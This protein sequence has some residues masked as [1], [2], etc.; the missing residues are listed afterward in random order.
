[1]FGRLQIL[2][3]SML[4][5]VLG[6]ALL[7]DPQPAASTQHLPT[8]V[9]GVL[10]ATPSVGPTE[11]VSEG[12]VD[13][14]NTND[15]V[16]LPAKVVI[17]WGGQVTAVWYRPDADVGFRGGRLFAS[18]RDTAGVWSNPVAVSQAFAYPFGVRFDVAAGRGPAASIVWTARFDG[19]NYVFEAH[20]DEIGWSSPSMLG[21]GN[22]NEPRVVMDGHGNTT[23]LWYR[24]GPRVATRPADGAW[25]APRV[26]RRG[27]GSPPWALTANRAGDEALVWRVDNGLRAT[28]RARTSNHWTRAVAVPGRVGDFVALAIDR[29]GRALAAWS[30]AGSIQWAR[31]SLHGRWSSARK[32]PGDVGRIGEYGWLDLSVNRRGR[33]LVRWTADTGTYVAR[34]QPGAGFR[35]AVHLGRLFRAEDSPLLTAG[36]T[37]IVAGKEPVKFFV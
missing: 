31:R 28:F 29:R 9:S 30:T 33:G 23:A 13:V 22:R 10:A 32:I 5:M 12:A 26:F 17:G 7:V 16:G 27:G 37:A 19:A 14:A 1:M 20:R 36:R 3:A 15:G 11:T 18:V 25:S 21:R 4:G 24:R 6:G 35:R 2:S 8:R 34:Y